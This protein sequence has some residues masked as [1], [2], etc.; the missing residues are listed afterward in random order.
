[1]PTTTDD[2]AFLVELQKFAVQA[3]ALASKLSGALA[4]GLRKLPDERW[5]CSAPSTRE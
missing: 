5:S 1:M 4:M 3:K 2:K